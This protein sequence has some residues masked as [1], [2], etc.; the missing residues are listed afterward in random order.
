MIGKI[1]FAEQALNKVPAI[2]TNEMEFKLR[3][4]IINDLEGLHKVKDRS[5][6]SIALLNS[7]ID[8]IKFKINPENNNN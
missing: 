5:E 2:P 7:R 4:Q 6:A 1:A 3:N 8:F